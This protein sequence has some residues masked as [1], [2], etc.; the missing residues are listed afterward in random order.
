MLRDISD[1]GNYVLATQAMQSLARCVGIDAIAGY[2]ADGL[3][4]VAQIAKQAPRAISIAAYI[5]TSARHALART[6][7]A[8]GSR[9]RNGH[10]RPSAG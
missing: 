1:L 5:H 6:L 2:I 4:I 9:F 8:T 10:V 7:Q 3:Q